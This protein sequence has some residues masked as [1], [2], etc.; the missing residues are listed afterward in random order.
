MRIE[1]FLEGLGR[2]AIQ[3]ELGLDA[4]ALVRPTTDARHGDYQLNG[5]LP[6]AKQL[7]K[8]P[9]E[10]AEAVARGLLTEPAIEKAEVAGP[11]FVNLRLRDDWLAEHLS[12]ALRDRERD[13]VPR[14][15]RT[16]RVIVDFSGPNI[17][18][19]MHVGHLRS[20]IIGDS[21]VR[22]LRFLGHE[23]IGDNHLGDWGTQFGLL[24]VGMR[25]FGDEA[26][27]TS[28]PI[29]EL[30]RIYKQA[31]ER[32]KTD[33][34]FAAA[35]RSELAKLQAGDPENTALWR[36]FVEVTKQELD[37]VYERLD[38]RFDTWYGESFYH[39]MLEGVVQLLKEKGIAREDQGAVCVFFQELE[40]APADLKK[41]KEPLIVQK[42]DGAYLY[43]TT[44][45][46]TLRYRREVQHADRVIYVVD[47]RQS[48]HFKQVFA[49]AKLLGW[50]AMRCEH[51]GFGSVLGRDGKPLKTRDAHG[52]AIT[53]ASLL[54]EAEQRALTRLREGKSEGKIDLSDE[55][56]VSI[57][58]AVGIGAVKY[59]DL[60]Q[61]RA[62]D[63]QF[64]FDKMITFQGN[65]GPY[66]QYAYARVKSIF[67]RG[68]VDPDALTGHVVLEAPEERV[69][70]R[71]LARFGEVIHQAGESGLP[72]LIS[73]HLYELAR[74]YSTFFE[75]CPV[76]KSDGS[77]RESRLALCA[78]TA[79][80][81]QR[82]LGLLGIS[83]VE[84]M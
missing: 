38:V 17:A 8:N 67:R 83:V 64:D 75:A 26:A 20:T 11:G 13:G 6:L 69:L 10:L 35:A 29:V 22:T 45:L 27:L 34:A 9:R 15:E 80:Q 84:R 56:L 28:E 71:V 58:R 25:A 63:Y 52:K 79:R 60:H 53:L 78:L 24:I 77:T 82:G 66:M 50:G 2:S 1:R 41:Q 57:A 62:S 3:R 43:S 32:A 4:P 44:D 81:L 54:D 65:A 48:L 68:G 12:E 16:E 72:H 47:M 31:S 76:L 61:N 23:V 73:D 55:E 42:Q 30:E 59:A 36:R 21:L 51:L 49:V 70:G 40:D 74:A 18:K 37:K 5:V 46:A 33:E 14:S 19:Q 39:G 7:K